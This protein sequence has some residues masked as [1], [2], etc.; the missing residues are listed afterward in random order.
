MSKIKK[1][2][3]SL[4][5]S[6]MLLSMLPLK[7]LA[8]E[9][10]P[11]FNDVNGREYFAQA[12]GALTRLGI[13]QGYPDGAFKAARN[14]T[15]TEM[16]VIIIRALG[17]EGEVKAGPLTTGYKDVVAGHWAGAYINKAAELKIIQGDGNGKFRPDDNVK[18]EETVK[19]VAEAVG[20]G[21][22][23]TVAG[24]WPDGY[25]KVAGDKGLLK[26]VPGQKGA[27]AIRGAVALMVY[28][29]LCS[30][31]KAPTASLVEGSY[32]TTQKVT[33]S[34]QTAE[35]KIYYT[36]D[37]SEPGLNSTEY[38]T[39]ITVDKTLA[40]KAISVKSGAF[41]S[42]VFT[43][44]YAIGADPPAPDDGGG[45]GGSGGG[46]GGGDGGNGGGG[47]TTYYSVSFESNGGSALAKQSVIAGAKAIKP[48]D[49]AKPGSVFGGWFTDL[50]LSK[51]F[52]FAAP[53]IHDITLYAKW[54]DLPRDP[55]L[56]TE[57]PRIKIVTDFPEGKTTQ[58]AFDIVYTAVASLGAEIEEVSYRINGGAPD[59][60]Y[61]RGGNGISP[62]G[63]IG[64][65]RV[66]PVP[67]KNKIV[68]TIKDT[69]GKSAGF[70]VSTTPDY[71]FGNLP[72]EYDE[73]AF[74]VF[75]K[76]GIRA[77]QVSAAVKE[78]NGRITG[79]I[80]AIGLYYIAVPGSKEAFLKKYPDL[81]EFA[82][83]E[84]NLYCTAV[85]KKERREASTN[86]KQIDPNSKLKTQHSTLGLQS[87]PA[88]EGPLKGGAVKSRMDWDIIGPLIGGA[89]H[90]QDPWWDRE[91]Q[92]GVDAI[93]VPDVWS[94]YGYRL[95]DIKIGAGD[96]G[97]RLSHEDLQLTESNIINRPRTADDDHG[98][99]VMGTIGA[100]HNNK[101]GL[102]GTKDFNRADLYGY[103]VCDAGPE[104]ACDEGL[105]D[106]L[107]WNVLNGAKIINFSFGYLAGK[108]P[109]KEQQQFYGTVIQRLLDLGYDF[110]IVNSAGNA[111]T[112]AGQNGVFLCV[113]DPKLQERII[114]VGATDP[115]GR[116]AY[117]SN[118]GP[119]IDVVAPGMKIYSS[120]AHNNGRDSNS[121]YEYYDGTSM[122]APHVVGVAALV[123]S[124]NPGLKGTQ[125]KQIIKDS[126][127]DY[128]RIVRET[129]SYLPEAQGMTYY[130]INAKAAVDLALGQMPEIA[131]GVIRGQV[132]GVDEAQ[133]YMWKGSP[134]GNAELELRLEANGPV[135]ARAATDKH[136]DYVINNIREGLYYL[137]ASA[138][139]Y[140]S[141]TMLVD[142]S[143]DSYQIIG[144]VPEKTEPCLFKGK[145]KNAATGLP[146]TGKVDLTFYRVADSDLLAEAP[147]AARITAA[148][149]EFSLELPPG[150][151]I[152]EYSGKGYYPA[153]ILFY[154]LGGQ[155]FNGD[156]RI[157]SWYDFEDPQI[158]IEVT[159]AEGSL[160]LDAHLI[161]PRFAGDSFHLWYWDN[162]FFEYG[163]IDG[164]YKNILYATLWAD[165][166]VG[167]ARE[168][169]DIYHLKEGRYDYYLQD[170]S[171][172]D[173]INSMF[174]AGSEAVVNVFEKN[175]EL[176]ASF[177]VPVTE[178][179]SIWHVFSLEVRGGKYSIVPVNKMMNEPTQSE[180]VGKR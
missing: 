147:V 50:E 106:G 109:T 19:I 74:T 170:Y 16:V 31:V 45:N 33:L 67:G 68:F 72:T 152:V 124:A 113:T 123:W 36:L 34:T 139:G 126:A 174:L 90:T 179:G 78:T 129:R 155:V 111:Q 153:S 128:G 76:E 118:Y 134:L 12:A 15:R 4:L 85:I 46:G 96:T 157:Q 62:K 180:D 142:V 71:D 163:T 169:V 112:D 140:I 37:G 144:L 47:T 145:I 171:H 14:I 48:A 108:D 173:E 66:F 58:A 102:A 23:A 87:S 164:Y 93:K 162:M 83:A 136:G 166:A 10:L 8:G 116:M 120:V 27:A 138:P 32:P 38:K 56:P 79:Q 91:Y 101:L 81:F 107:I 49:P 98:T 88:E 20:L 25:L 92:W 43:A 6:L 84:D 3:A 9:D 13:L 99:H 133:I 103:D 156:L 77:D 132:A 159:W 95:R 30:Q 161:C 63:S 177:G 52:D 160:D 60:L 61:L 143:G 22:E 176:L 54:A 18:Y 70:E 53:I 57:N 115:W 110:V 178:P 80:Y 141:E 24:G 117:F 2:A 41:N 148:N 89:V 121:S 51:G 168:D 69:A 154:A 158:S 17:L 122:S 146:V 28:Q 151:Y 75:A 1:L 114:A 21:S 127:Q 130:Q 40:L 104:A 65:G 55:D 175:G 26:N 172:W 5:I 150:S 29:A 131:R 119:R 167:A 44:Q 7:A 59:Y 73:E 137:E 94:S 105:I 42:Q 135:L 165:G 86:K 100:I 97:F 11:P 64:F 35:A 125:V 82:Y 149:G 39:E